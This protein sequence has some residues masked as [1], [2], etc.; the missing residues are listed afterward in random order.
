MSCK[1]GKGA[2]G[3][4]TEATSAATPETAEGASDLLYKRMDVLGVTTSDVERFAGGMTEEL[5]KACA[6]CADKEECR[7]DLATS[8]DDPKWAEY[9]PNNQALTAFKRLRGRFPI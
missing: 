4:A 5:E 7:S 2:C 6:C 8:P 1:S 9:C 3:C